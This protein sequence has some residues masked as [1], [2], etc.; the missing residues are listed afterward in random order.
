MMSKKSGGY[1]LIAL[2]PVLDIII[3][4]CFHGDLLETFYSIFSI[5]IILVFFVRNGDSIF[6]KRI[7]KSDFMII[8]ISF[9]FLLINV[10]LIEGRL[11][12]AVLDTTYFVLLMEIYNE[13][14]FIEKYTATLASKC[15]ILTISSLIYLF[16][17]LMTIRRG[18]AFSTEWSS[19][20]LKGPYSIPHILAYELLVLA[21][22]N[23]SMFQING[24]KIN[25]VIGIVFLCCILVTAVRGA[26]LAETV[27]LAFY[28]YK[29][30]FKKKYIFIFC[31]V[32][33]LLYSTINTTIYNYLWAPLMKKN[34]FA[35]SSGS[36]DNGRI[37]I[38]RASVASFVQKDGIIKWFFG[39]GYSNLLSGNKRN[40]G[41]AIQAHN[42]FLTVPICFGLVFFVTLFI[43]GFVKLVK[44]K[45]IVWA[46]L[47][48]SLLAGFN[49]MV[50]Y[51][52]MVIGCINII[53]LFKNNRIFQREHKQENSRFRKI[54]GRPFLNKNTK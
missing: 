6:T 47:F 43:R 32:I 26:I 14:K 13:N 35:I 44:G 37:N 29:V 34:S 8:V 36:L 19:F 40:I 4:Y 31:G 1:L 28:F 24:K 41:M 7:R 16:V 5:L 53:V 48:F 33:L 11:N 10:I 15:R 52:P 54:N 45:N 3:A 9:V 38:W 20:T 23:I 25:I 42:D 17:L 18:D 30:G 51:M 49:G 2:F 21:S 27:L 46:L 39:I 12:T 50:L 22:M